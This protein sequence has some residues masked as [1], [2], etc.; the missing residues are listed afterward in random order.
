MTGR[1]TSAFFIT[2]CLQSGRPL[3]QMKRSSGEHFSR[4]LWRQRNL[5]QRL[6]RSFRVPD[7]KLTGSRQL[8]IVSLFGSLENRLNSV[9]PSKLCPI[10][11]GE[12]VCHPPYPA[13]QESTAQ[14]HSQL[15]QDHTKEPR[16][17][18]GLLTSKAGSSLL[19][20]SCCTFPHSPQY[21]DSL[22]R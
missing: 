15:A 9:L 17:N 16:L 13:H 4:A 12:V 22:G 1:Q 7:E 11:G 6:F 14:R 18:V 3:I 5:F 21:T 10:L 20:D 8:G 19:H 2:N